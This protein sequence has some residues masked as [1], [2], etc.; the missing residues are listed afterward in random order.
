M[1]GRKRRGKKEKKEGAHL[2]NNIFPAVFVID[3]IANDE[4]IGLRI[5]QWTQSIVIILSGG[6][7]ECN[8]AV[9]LVTIKYCRNKLFCEGS[10]RMTDQ[11]AGFS[12]APIQKREIPRDFW[13][14]FCFN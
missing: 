9:V 4:D 3:S 13:K 8:P 1:R 10:C 7:P 12:D 14:D 11:E 5:R 6:I 2:F